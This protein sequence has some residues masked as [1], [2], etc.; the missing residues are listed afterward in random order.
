MITTIVAWVA[1]A[2]ALPALGVAVLLVFI[3]SAEMRY[4]ERYAARQRRLERLCLRHFWQTHPP[5]KDRAVWLN[6]ADFNDLAND[7]RAEVW[8]VSNK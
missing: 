5:D 6:S 2:F 3:L 8:E 4:A 1:L 7:H